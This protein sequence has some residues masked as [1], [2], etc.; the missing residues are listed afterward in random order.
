MT[1]SRAPLRLVHAAAGEKAGLQ[2]PLGPRRWAP[3]RRL[4]RTARRYPVV[5][6]FGAALLALA[7]VAVFA[8]ALAPY[9]QFQTHPAQALQSPSAAHWLGTDELGRDTLSRVIFGTRV[10]LEVAAIAVG[11]G[12]V[13]GVVLG[14]LAGYLGG[15]ADQVISRYIDGQLAFPGLLLAIAISNALGPSLAHAMIAVG[16]TGIPVYMRLTRGQ[17]L[18]ARELEYVTAARVLGAGRLRIM[19]RHVLPTV[20]GPLIVVGS[21][22]AGGAILTE[23]SLSFLGIGAQPPTPDLG[24]MI[25]TAKDYL[26]NQAWLAVGPGVAIFLIVWSFAN[27]GDALHDAL[28]PRLRRR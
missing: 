6:L 1:T 12:I 10:S 27:I 15:L 24:S 21:L 14:L 18:Q 28:D 22:A 7:L 2:A 19:L 8:P 5:T 4:V 25:N 9:S 20:I 11:I 16:V 23:A 26:E 17:V 13:V 3:F